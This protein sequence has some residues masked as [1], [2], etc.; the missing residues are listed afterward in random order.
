MNKYTNQSKWHR[1]EKQNC[2]LHRITAK[3]R[4]TSKLRA[5]TRNVNIIF[6]T[7]PL[8]DKME[9]TTAQPMNLTKKQNL[10]HLP[11]LDQ[12][13]ISQSREVFP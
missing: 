11:E 13:A 12:V 2:S 9:R 1:L 4:S 7:F 5:Y 6:P 8:L 3:H 10:H